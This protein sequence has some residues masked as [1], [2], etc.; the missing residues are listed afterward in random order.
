MTEKSRAWD[1]SAAPLFD[2]TINSIPSS[3]C[4]SE[5]IGADTSGKERRKFVVVVY[6]VGRRR[7]MGALHNGQSVEFSFHSEPS[8]S[9]EVCQRVGRLSI[10]GRE[11]I[12]TP[13]FLASTSR[14]VIPH[15]TPDVLARH[16]FTCGAFIAL[17]DC[18]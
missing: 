2:I 4:L 6:L 13:N 1:L 8:S 10:P 16:T 11:P 12:S 9:S 17:E 14:G 5:V 7:T 3:R 18:E 15:L